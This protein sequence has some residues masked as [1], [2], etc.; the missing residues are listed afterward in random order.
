MSDEEFDENALEFGE[1]GF[2]EGEEE[3]GVESDRETTPLS[4]SNKRI[5]Q[6]PIDRLSELPDSLLV[7]IL[8]FLYTS[9]LQAR[10]PLLF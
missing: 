6:M 9:F 3:C 7:Q 8:S 2:G 5:K 1:E 4:S 10:C